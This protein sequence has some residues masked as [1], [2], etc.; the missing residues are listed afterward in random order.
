MVAGVALLQVEHAVPQVAGVVVVEVLAAAGGRRGGAGATRGA[1]GKVAGAGGRGGRAQVEAK[2]CDAGGDVH[3]AEGIYGRGVVDLVY[4]V[5][6]CS[7]P[8][9]SCSRVL[10]VCQA[11]EGGRRGKKKWTAR[12]TVDSYKPKGRRDEKWGSH[13]PLCSVQGV[14]AY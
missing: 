3:V 9:V 13:G 8:G 14:W 4:Q 11:F 2:H 5:C 10:S 1:R 6:G 12:W 7:R